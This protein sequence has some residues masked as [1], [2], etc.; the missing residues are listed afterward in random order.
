MIKHHHFRF[1]LLT[2]TKGKQEG[3]H[4]SSSVRCSST[5][6]T[7]QK[8]NESHCTFCFT[9]TTSVQFTCVCVIYM[10]RDRSISVYDFLNIHIYVV[11]IY[12]QSIIHNL[13]HYHSSEQFIKMTNELMIMI[14][15]VYK[16]DIQ[17]KR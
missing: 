4:R 5:R 13:H 3:E 17:R 7:E 6:V 9:M 8:R 14:Q 1:I 11:I 10:S 12:V 16:M 2:T 15:T